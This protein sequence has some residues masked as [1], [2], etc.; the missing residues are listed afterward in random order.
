MLTEEFSY[1]LPEELI[2]Q[3]PTEKRDGSRLMVI[4]RKAGTIE[5]RMF[6][7]LPEY[8][9]ADDCLVLNNTQVYPARIFAL[10]RLKTS[11]IEVF[12]LHRRDDGVWETLMK[13]GRKAR[14][15]DRVYLGTKQI[16]AI[17]TDIL[18]D[19]RRVICV[20]GGDAAVTALMDVDGHI[21]L[22]P[23]IKRNDT[24]TD[25]TRYQTVFAKHEGS[26][27]APTAG[28]HFT[29]TLL[30][31]IKNNGTSVAEVTLHVGIGTFRPVEVE[32]VEEHE[33]H[34][35]WFQLTED[36][37]HTITTAR[38]SGGRIITVGTTATRVL[39][40]VA[41][42]GELHAQE[43]WSNLF[44]YPGYT[45]RG[46]NGLLTNFHL[47]RSSLLMLVSAFAGTELIRR[48][49]ETAVKEKYRFFSYGD[50][51]LIL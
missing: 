50:A 27:A 42:Q 12:F 44:M 25:R 43:G 41:A 13:P 29:D 5:H 18:E 47:P 1:I 3:H 33:M 11:K 30:D 40:T 10:N 8:L 24:N 17:V 6:S 51:M 22:P 49:Y 14:K 16:P 34:R 46:I 9:Y 31:N 28:L 7:D 32:V 4:D 2:A 37:A 36:A 19:G 45:F 48:A 26:V 39:E 20:E 15:D 35:E 21:P 38:Q 23:Y